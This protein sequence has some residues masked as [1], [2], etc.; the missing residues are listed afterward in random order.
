MRSMEKSTRTKTFIVSGALLTLASILF[1]L[2]I[3]LSG[4][5]LRSLDLIAYHRLFPPSS[6]VATTMWY[7]LSALGDTPTIAL[8]STLIFLLLVGRGRMRSALSLVCAILAAMSL[9]ELLKYLLMVKRPLVNLV[10]ATSNAYPSGHTAM[11]AALCMLI[12]LS[13]V[14]YKN[15]WLMKLLVAS[16]CVILTLLISL[17][18]LLLGAHWLSDV[19]GGILL[20]CGVSLFTTG[21]VNL[22][23]D[24]RKVVHT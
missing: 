9:T 2:T 7:T 15:N 3:S 6:E 12:L 13:L 17:S 23:A 14:P 20:G 8:L 10:A 11:I 18:R 16:A 5:P 22:F 24:K 1:G 21:I 4:N 19:I